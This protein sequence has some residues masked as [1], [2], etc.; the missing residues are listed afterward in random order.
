MCSLCWRKTREGVIWISIQGELH[1]HFKM[2]INP[3][4]VQKSSQSNFLD[5]KN[6]YITF[7]PASRKSGVYPTT[8]DHK[9]EVH[10]A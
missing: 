10:E 5:W 9:S 3:R 4:Q 2:Q 1:V 7:I 8:S 6:F